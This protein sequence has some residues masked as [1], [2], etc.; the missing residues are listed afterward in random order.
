MQ[1]HTV[2]IIGN[3]ESIKNV[4]PKL[5]LSRELDK[6]LDTSYRGAIGIL[7]NC[8][9]DV[10]LVMVDES[11]PQALEICKKIKTDSRFSLTPVIFYIEKKYNEEFM[12]EAFSLGLDDFIYCPVKDTEIS[13]R[14]KANLKKRTA[15]QNLQN[16]QIFLKDFEVLTQDGIY[17]QKYTTKVFDINVDNVKNYNHSFILMLFSYSDSVELVR[18][19]KNHARL[20]DTIGHLS[21]N[22]YYL[23]MPKTTLKRSKSFYKKIKDNLD[24]EVNASACEYNRKMN[25]KEITTIALKALREAS[26]IGNNIVATSFSDTE[27][28]AGSVAQKRVKNYKLFQKAFDKKTQNVILPAFNNIKVHLDEKYPYNIKIDFFAT[29]TKCYFSMKHLPSEI[30]T[31]M[32]I[33]YLGHSKLEVETI[34]TH[35]NHQTINSMDFDLN[36]LTDKIIGKVVNNIIVEFDRVVK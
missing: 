7:K 5:G 12:K 2:L 16:Q 3:N 32:K 10:I 20:S 36:D 25:F 6:V 27:T 15:F 31:A 8:V 1:N 19:L 21:S 23:I 33:N 24:G 4:K 29:G 28:F 35:K 14:V 30:E 11:E 9:P 22:I 17:S 13:L 18:Q 34:Y 26:A